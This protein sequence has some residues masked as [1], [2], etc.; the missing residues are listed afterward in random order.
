MRG[1][2]GD[3]GAV[4]TLLVVILSTGLL[5]G[6]GA[7]V[8]D[9]G[10]QLAERRQVQNGADA[11]ALA[12]V[13]TCATQPTCT[14]TAAVA[15]PWVVANDGRSAADGTAG[16]HSVCRGGPSGP[17]PCSTPAGGGVLTS[18]L[19][20]PAGAQRTWTGFV[21]VRVQ[22]QVP[23]LMGSALGSDGT[24][25]AACARASWGPVAELD[26]DFPAAVS[27]C[28]YNYFTRGGQLAAAPPYAA[29][30]PR[31]GAREVVV[32]LK[33]DPSGADTSCA[34]GQPSGPDVPGGFGWIDTDRACRAA[35]LDA[36][37]VV[38]A[39]PGSSP[40][41]RCRNTI[42]ASLETVVW[43]PVYDRVRGSGNNAR[44]R[45]SGF[46]GLYLSGYSLGPGGLR[47]PGDSHEAC[48]AGP[49]ADGDR[50]LY[51]WFVGGLAPG[52]AIGDADD[53]GARA[54]QLTG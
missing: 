4:A 6:T 1:L 20:P 28:Q 12:L 3:E 48:S 54:V 51:G 22:A 29:G 41:T 46:A 34:A 11:A 21:E 2:S 37:G 39:D 52:S 44:Y 15:E 42:R 9:Y 45:I 5:L 26:A 10:A 24:S 7:M 8:L 36:G 40:P 49:G 31:P 38:G 18:C 13:Q 23:A 27:V 30:N 50:C 32:F 47:D 17:L 43:I 16:V 33:D 35:G 25:A 53:Y 19:P 14:P